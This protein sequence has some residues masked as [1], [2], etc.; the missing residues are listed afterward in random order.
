M[1]AGGSIP[2]QCE[3]IH[4]DTGIVEVGQSGRDES[5]EPTGPVGAPRGGLLRPVFCGPVTDGG[6]RDPFGRGKGGHLRARRGPVIALPTRSG[7]DPLMANAKGGAEINYNAGKKSHLFLAS[8]DTPFTDHT[9]AKS[10]EDKT[11]PH[12]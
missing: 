11:N 9:V 12:A 4:Q 2:S 6:G 1:M 10:V 8:G 7:G 3:S 5:P